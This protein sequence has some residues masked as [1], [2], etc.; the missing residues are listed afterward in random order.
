MACCGLVL[1]NRIVLPLARGELS[2]GG[3]KR[4][5]CQ[6]QLYGK[7]SQLQSGDPAFGAGFQRGNVFCREIQ[8]HHLVEKIGSFDGRET[9]VGGAQLGERMGEIH[10]QIGK[11]ATQRN[12]WKSSVH[13][14]IRF[15][16]ISNV[17]MPSPGTGT[18]RWHRRPRS[19]CPEQTGRD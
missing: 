14:N 9:Q 1:W 17:A 3:C 13:L 8:S 19:Q 4:N 10:L 18:S 16:R 11:L 5:I 12:Y 15:L 2:I 6:I 7:R